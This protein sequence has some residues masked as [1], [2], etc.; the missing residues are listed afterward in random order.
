MGAHI[1]GC[2]W[3]GEKTLAEMLTEAESEREAVCVAARDAQCRMYGGGADGEQ[4]GHGGGFPSAAERV[5][6]GSRKL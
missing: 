5:E 2:Y 1:P 3:C 4:E 6:F